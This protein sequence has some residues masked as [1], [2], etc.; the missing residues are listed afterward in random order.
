M[1]QFTIDVPNDKVEMVGRAFGVIQGQNDP[2]E[3]AAQAWERLKE[4]LIWNLKRNVISMRQRELS[5]AQ[6][7]TDATNSIGEV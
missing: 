3:T 1:P 6:V 4:Q 5:Q 2:N 7:T